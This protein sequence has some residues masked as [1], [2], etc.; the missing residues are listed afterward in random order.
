MKIMC[1]TLVFSRKKLF[2]Y[3]NRRNKY[4]FMKKGMFFYDLIKISLIMEKK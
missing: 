2:E 1:F 4:V 3:S